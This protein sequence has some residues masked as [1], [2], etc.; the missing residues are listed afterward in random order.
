[1]RFPICQNCPWRSGQNY[2][3]LKL[4]P[5]LNRFNP[6]RERDLERDLEPPRERDLEPPREQDLERDRELHR[7]RDLER[8]LER[9]RELHREL[10]RERDLERDRELHREPDP[11]PPVLKDRKFQ[12]R[13]PKGFPT[14]RIYPWELALNNS[15][16][17]L[18]PPHSKRLLVHRL[19]L[20]PPRFRL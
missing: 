2:L 6:S 16:Q 3:Q 9:D 8:D 18:D 12:S 20:N 15:L 7:E 19:P 10:H 4:S 5:K 14:F 1:V 17:D 13:L 11:E